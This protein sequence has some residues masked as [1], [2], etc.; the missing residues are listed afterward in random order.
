MSI[1]KKMFGFP[2]SSD[3]DSVRFY[4]AKNLPY[5][6]RLQ[7]AFGF[8]L[9]GL[10]L[11][12]IFLN[13]FWGIPF[14]LTGVLLLLVR[15]YDSRI[16]LKTFSIDPDWSNVDIHKIRELEDLRN[17]SRK[18]DRDSLDISNFKGCFSLLGLLILG[19]AIAIVAGVVTAN[20]HVTLILLV[21]AAILMIPFWFTGM[22]LIL[23][24]PNLAIKVKIILKLYD[25][26]Q[27][28]KSSGEKFKPAIMVSSG[29]DGKTV[30][31]DTR[32]SVGFDSVPDNFYGLQAQ[33]NINLVQGTSYPYFYCVI[34]AK[35]GFGLSRYHKQIPLEQ[36]IICE[37]QADNQAEVLV[38]RQK[39]TKKSGYHT[40]EAICKTTLECALNGARLILSDQK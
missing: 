17:R 25:A 34:A 37:Y 8:I 30:P 9:T 4:L 22:R 33:I 24:Q 18:W 6:L 38:I 31:I 32:F 3:R 35:P 15:G 13:V 26:F 36:K 39:T 12:V 5:G 40:R 29:K 10:I 23:K 20:A 1:M 11:Q 7:L 14:V 21:D 28:M 27:I 16:R 2:S 19:F